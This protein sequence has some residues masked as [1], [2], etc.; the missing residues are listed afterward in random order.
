M[1]PKMDP[2][3][4]IYDKWIHLNPITRWLAT[5]KQQKV[6]S[7]DLHLYWMQALHFGMIGVVFPKL[8]Q[9]LPTADP[10][11]FH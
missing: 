6:F 11:D 3:K 10:E 9:K 1:V 8:L 4:W 2:T 7:F 5:K